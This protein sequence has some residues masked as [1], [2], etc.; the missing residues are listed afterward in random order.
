MTLVQ[1]NFSQF[2][3]R[4]GGFKEIKPGFDTQDWALFELG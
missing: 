1:K 2:Q 4:L 3:T